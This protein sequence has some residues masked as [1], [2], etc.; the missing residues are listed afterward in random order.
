[1]TNTTTQLYILF[2]K[3]YL[4]VLKIFC[5]YYIPSTVK[6]LEYTQKNEGKIYILQKAL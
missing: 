1:M 3:K 6:S 5:A 2:N 4:N